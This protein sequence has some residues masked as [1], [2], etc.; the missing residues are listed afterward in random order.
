VVMS[1]Q[2]RVGV[3]GWR[4]PPWRKQFYPEGL[5]Q[6]DELTYLASKLNSVE[7]NGTFYA[8]QRPESF[9]RWYQQTPADFRFAVKGARYITH[10][11]RLAD[12]DAALANVFASGPLALGDKLGP[13]LWQLPPNMTFEPDRVSNFLDLL[14]RTGTEAVE[15]ARRHEERME[16]RTWLRCDGVERIRHAIEVRHDSFRNATFASLLRDHNVALVLADTAGRWPVL[17]EDTADFRYLRL[18]GDKELYISGYGDKALKRWAR[19]IAGWAPQDAFIYFDNDVK[20]YAPTDAMRLSTLLGG[21]S[22]SE[23]VRVRPRASAARRP[24]PRSPR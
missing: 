7:I 1:R 16:G 20:A 6:A 3:S 11:K 21:A 18:H 19:E 9:Q 22:V 4:Y 14:P 17:R 15:L 13:F 2:V 8:L 23:S 24:E 10:M 12:V 5:R